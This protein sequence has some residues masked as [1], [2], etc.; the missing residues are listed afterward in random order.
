MLLLVLCVS[1][2]QLA[3]YMSLRNLQMSHMGCTMQ[4]QHYYARS[5]AFPSN[6]YQRTADTYDLDYHHQILIIP[7][8]QD[9]VLPQQKI[10]V[11]TF[12]KLPS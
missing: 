3:Q 4:I 8:S 1:T 10:L 11:G 6:L 2:V 9:M 7:R 12:C 5:P